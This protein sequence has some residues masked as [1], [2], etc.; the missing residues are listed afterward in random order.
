MIEL[1]IKHESGELR[2]P[3]TGLGGEATRES[4]DNVISLYEIGDRLIKGNVGL[5]EFSYSS[6]FPDPQ[7]DYS[8]VDHKDYPAPYDCCEQ[9]LQWQE[10]EE[11][12]RLILTETNINIPGRI[13]SFSYREDDQS[14]S[15]S[16][17]ITITECPPLVET[18]PTPAGEYDKAEHRPREATL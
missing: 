10:E 9:M 8:F 17:D 14:G 5:R 15:V 18:T 13:T 6:F 4:N 11:P 3:F 16:Y 1:W 2:L 7:K 12:I